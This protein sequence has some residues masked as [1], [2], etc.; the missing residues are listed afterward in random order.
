M[1]RT[2]LL[3]LAVLPYATLLALDAWMHERA[4]QVPRLEQWLHAGLALGIG[5]FL[6]A[7]F[8]DRTAL[9]F[10]VLGLTSILMIWDELGFHQGLSRRERLVHLLTFFALIGFI[11]IWRWSEGKL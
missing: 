6:L 2:T 8:L 3:A 10:T 7:A 9:A 11:T 1:T 5:S 4:R